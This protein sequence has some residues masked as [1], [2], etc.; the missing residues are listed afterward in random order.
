MLKEQIDQSKCTLPG[1]WDAFS[2]KWRGREM[3]RK[4]P[5]GKVDLVQ[6]KEK[7]LRNKVSMAVRSL[8]TI[9]DKKIRE[10]LKDR[11]EMKNAQQIV[12]SRQEYH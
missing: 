6:Q 7:I 9:R 11:N 2:E 3:S 4:R 12:Q 8:L 10:I 5:D 1:P